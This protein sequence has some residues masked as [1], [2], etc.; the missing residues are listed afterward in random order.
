MA[1]AVLLFSEQKVASR[2]RNLTMHNDV[3]ASTERDRAFVSCRIKR[4]DIEL[5]EIVV[6]KEPG[7]QLGTSRSRRMNWARIWD[8]KSCSHRMRR[9][10][11]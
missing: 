9:R 10:K 7:F 8:N 4:R 11:L 3:V 6:R 1:P 2:G 5:T